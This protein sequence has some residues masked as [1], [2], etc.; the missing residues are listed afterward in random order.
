MQKLPLTLLN[1]PTGNDG[2]FLKVENGKVVPAAAPAGGGGT[3]YTAGSGIT[4]N[5]TIIGTSAATT[6]APGS[7]SAADKV[8][9]DGLSAETYSTI[10]SKLAGGSGGGTT[11]FLRAD[12]T[13][14]APPAG[15]AGGSS[16][17]DNVTLTGTTKF[18]ATTGMTINATTGATYLKAVN[19]ESL[20]LMSGYISN[21]EYRHPANGYSVFNTGLRVGGEKSFGYE[22]G[23]GGGGTV[24]QTNGQTFAVT[25]NKPTGRINT[26]GSSISPNTTVSFAVGN[27]TVTVNDVVIVNAVSASP[28]LAIIWVSMNNSNGNFYVNI[29]N[30]ATFAIS[31][32]AINFAVI[33]GSVN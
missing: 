17:T 22:P 13:F 24:T 21:A 11:N 8:K 23:Y 19:V 25:I 15:S 32:S 28:N 5:G 29:Y 10:T 4:I 1:I 6:T 18:G 12:G 7:M 3:T 27:S 20:S 30:P 2:L 31:V 9:L 26:F 33:K 14:A 16:S